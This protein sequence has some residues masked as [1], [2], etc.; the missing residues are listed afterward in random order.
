M[1]RIERI[2][3]SGQSTYEIVLGRG[4]LDEVATSLGTA[5]KKVLLVYPEPLQNSADSLADSLSEKGLEVWQFPVA[6]GEDAKTDRWLAVAW[7]SLGQAGFSRSDAVVSLGGGTT[8]DLA[9]FIAST[10]L[11]GIPVVHIPTTLLAM[12]DAAIGGKTGINTL[13]GKNLVGAFFDPKSVIADLDSLETLPKIELGSGFAEIIK[14][15]FIADPEILNLIEEDLTEATDT[16]SERF[17]ELVRRA[18]AVKVDVVGRDFKESNLRE[19]LNYGHTLGHSIE[20]AEHFKIKHGH[21]VSIG[22]CF[23]AELARLTAKLSDEVADRHS[24][25]LSKIGLPTK[26]PKERWEAL[27]KGM[28]IDKKSRGGILRFVVLEGLGRPTILEAQTEEILF[29]AFLEI[30]S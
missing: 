26:Y 1:T 2:S 16:K 24:E 22:M 5:V 17:A 6:D 30:A 29:Q 15:G 11:R 14:C 7:S 27:Y 23:V 3:A 10:W 13:E 19:I 28:Q 25:L 20:L 4:L 12:V 21:A 8:T 18:I 9:G